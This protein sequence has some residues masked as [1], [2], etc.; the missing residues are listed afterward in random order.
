MINTIVIPTD[1][2]DTALRAVKYGIGLAKKF[3]AKIIVVSV[4]QYPIV[5]AH[6]G[7]PILYEPISDGFDKAANEN[8]SEAIDLIKAEGVAYDA[9]IEKG[10]PRFV[11]TTQVVDQFHPD[12]IVMGKTGTNALTRL[13]IGSTARYVAENAETNVLLVK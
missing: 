11:L 3:D 8:V 4:I 10:D 9:L 6:T 7:G 12:L 13:L 5:T 1:G 2:S